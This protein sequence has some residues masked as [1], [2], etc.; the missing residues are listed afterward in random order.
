MKRREENDLSLLHDIKESCALMLS[1]V[2][3]KTLT[4]YVADRELQDAVERRLTIIGEAAKALTPAT[5]RR[6]PSLPWADIGKFRDLAVHHYRTVD[7]VKVWN[8]IL[9]D[10]PV[11]MESI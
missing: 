11:L 6:F 9:A 3:G 2:E 4:D 1:Y 7:P 8:I 5:K 10:I